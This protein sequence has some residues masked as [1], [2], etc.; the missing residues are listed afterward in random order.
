MKS[1][2]QHF[3]APVSNS[4]PSDLQLDAF[5]LQGKPSDHPLRGHLATCLHCQERLSYMARIQEE[6][7]AQV[8]P[9]TIGQVLAQAPAQRN[10]M[11]WFFSSLSWLSKPARLATASAL[12]LLLVVGAVL[13][14]RSSAN[15][16]PDY[17]GIK[18]TVGVQVWCRRGQQVFLARDGSVLHPGDALRFVPSVS[19]P[20]YLMIVSVDEQGRVSRYDQAPSPRAISVD[21]GERALDGSV[22]LDDTLGVE[23]IFVL[24]SNQAFDFDSVKHAIGIGAQGPGWVR[25]TIKLALPMDQTS[26][27]FLKENR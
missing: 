1:K 8:F 4:C 17:I 7:R 21:K 14:I 12:L 26:M 25:D 22:V 27:W 9:A 20:G 5:W 16:E 23:R 18:G 15:R 2:P 10:N 3:E 19:T 13:W 24:F 6:F 11:N